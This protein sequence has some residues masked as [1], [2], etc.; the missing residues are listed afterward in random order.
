MRKNEEMLQKELQRLIWNDRIV[1]PA[2]LSEEEVRRRVE[3]QEQAKPKRRSIGRFVTL[4]ATAAVLAVMLTAGLRAARKPPAKQPDGTRTEDF[5]SPPMRSAE[6]CSDPLTADVRPAEQPDANRGQRMNNEINM[7]SDD[8]A[9]QEGTCA[10]DYLI[11]REIDFGTAKQYFPNIN[12]CSAPNFVRYEVE[13]A[14][15]SNRAAAINYI[16]SDGRITVHDNTVAPFV[17]GDDL[18][19]SIKIEGRTYYVEKGHGVSDEHTLILLDDE[20]RLV[21][22]ASMRCS[23]GDLEELARAVEPLIAP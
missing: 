16:F 5:S 8:M 23:N 15:P 3:G 4:A 13:I 19:E 17:P 2:S 7:A 11:T 20:N 9:K 1:L 14:M 6:D 21:Y 12:E 22:T 10:F 18:Y